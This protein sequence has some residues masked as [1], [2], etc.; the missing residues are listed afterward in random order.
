MGLILTSHDLYLRLS[1]DIS[2]NDRQALPFILQE[3]TRTSCLKQLSK[4][5]STKRTDISENTSRTLSPAKPMSDNS[6]E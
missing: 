1:L 4:A 6:I 2:A 3:G 5:Q